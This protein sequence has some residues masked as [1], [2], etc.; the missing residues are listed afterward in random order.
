VLVLRAGER[1]AL[2]T[3][4][5]AFDE[6]LGDRAAIDGDEGTARTLAFA[7]DGACDQLL[8]D[9]ALALD[10]DRDLRFGGALA[11][12]DHLLH[13]GAFRDQILE[14]EGAGNLLVEPRELTRQRGQLER[15][16]D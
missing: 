12:A 3:E 2:V 6:L 7:L 5:D 8:A 9:A 15:I 14:G 1:A 11:E 4:E 13:R 16:Q 10:E